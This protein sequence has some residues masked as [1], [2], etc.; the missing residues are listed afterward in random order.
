M[1]WKDPYGVNFQNHQGKILTGRP[2]RGS[3]SPGRKDPYGINFQNHQGKI[4]TG[5]PVRID[6]GQEWIHSRRS[7]G[8][9]E[10]PA[11]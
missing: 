1:G 8:P 6:A 11:A 9:G 3:G 10:R 4:L 2:V 7:G 5:R